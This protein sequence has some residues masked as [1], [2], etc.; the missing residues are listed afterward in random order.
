MGSTGSSVVDYDLISESITDAILKFSIGEHNILSDYCT[1]YFSL[2]S[3]M[4]N[5]QTSA[6]DTQASE[7]VNKKFV[8]KS[9]ETQNYRDTINLNEEDILHVLM[10]TH[11]SQAISEQHINENIDRFSK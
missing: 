10:Q 3:T 9:E 4:H 1:V 6:N 11:L 2:S 8:L 7:R 5:L